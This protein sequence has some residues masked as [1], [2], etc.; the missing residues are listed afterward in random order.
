MADVATAAAGMLAEAVGGSPRVRGRVRVSPELVARASTAPPRLDA[1]RARGT[2]RRPHRGLRG[3]ARRRS[4]S[5][6]SA[7][8]PSSPAGSSPRSRGISRR[9][10]ASTAPRSRSGEPDP[11]LVAGHPYVPEGFDFAGRPQLVARFPG[12]GGGRS[13]LLERPRRRRLRRPARRLG[14]GPVRRGAPRRPRVRPRRLRHE[15][16]GRGDGLRG[17]RARAARRPPP[18]R[19]DREHG[20]RGGD[21]RRRRARERPHAGGRRGHRPRAQRAR[22]VD[23]VPR[24]AAVQRSTSRAAAAT[25]AFRPRTPA[26]AAR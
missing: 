23:R 6:S 3:R 14:V 21:D 4:S 9:S 26:R 18:R 10:W 13:L 2:G 8:T 24:L 25:P 17:D 22:G 19:P 7:S 5:S 1:G 16:R 12:G 11:E 20:E 15:G